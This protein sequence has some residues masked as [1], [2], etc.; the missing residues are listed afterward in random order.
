MDWSL[1]LELLGLVYP[2]FVA[3]GILCS[4]DAVLKSRT[5]QGTIAW[6]ICLLLFPFLAVPLYMIFG[7]RKFYG[8]IK[9]RRKGDSELHKIGENVI[10]EMSRF[11]PEIRDE[12]EPLVSLA[13]L[14]ITTGN[15]VQFF[16]DGNSKFTE[17]WDELKKAQK[18]IIVQY[19]MVHDDRTGI[20][21]QELLLQKSAS[22][23]PVYFLYDNIGSYETSSS[24]LRE[25]RKGGV[26]V[27]SFGSARFVKNKFQ[28]N[29]RNHRK[30][31]II[32]G[33]VA[34]C[35][36]MNVGDEYR[37]RNEALSPW[38]D[39]HLKISGPAVQGIQLVFLEDWCSMGGRV[40]D[41]DWDPKVTEGKSELLV[42][43]VG[44]ADERSN[45]M[46]SFLHA[47]NLAKEKLWIV[48]PY[49]VPPPE[50]ASAIELAA[51]RGVDVRIMVPSK[52]DNIMV[53]LSSLSFIDEFQ[54]TGVRFFRFKEGFLHQKVFLVDDSIGSVGTMNIDNRSFNINFELSVYGFDAAFT[55]TLEEM[56]VQ[57]FEMCEEIEASEYEQRSF[58]TKFA[59]RCSRLL[60]PLQ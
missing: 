35:G 54:K 38:R 19:Y 6:C 44:P 11:S 10:A 53:Q 48:S 40:P 41:L 7:G 9:A 22:G 37:G 27:V 29:F 14:P 58:F 1:A 21:L 52:A 55:S 34:F 4:I 2:V 39:T 18:Y 57:D 5:P 31:I 59:A 23:I 24:Y 42:L 28:I 36:G 15:E 12:K 32:D 56:L 60:A 17:V 50:V 46:L 49:F 47:C 8:Y 33:K 20:E 43:P 51:L 16:T 30:I 26:E 25:L 13:K 45:G 3:M